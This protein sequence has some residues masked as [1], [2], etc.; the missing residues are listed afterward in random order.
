MFI[1]IKQNF[2]KI[3]NCHERPYCRTL[4]NPGE[5]VSKIMILHAYDWDPELIAQAGITEG[6]IQKLTPLLEEYLATFKESFKRSEHVVLGHVYVKGLM[7]DLE[8]KSIEPIALRYLDERGVRNLQYF[9]KDA[10]WD[11]AKMLD[12]YQKRL[13]LIVGDSEAMITVDG[14]DFPKKGKNSVGVARQYCG[15]LG[16]TE[17]CQAGAFVGYSSKN[18]YGLVNCRLYMPEKWFSDEYKDR[19]KAC[20]IPDD[21]TFKTKTEIAAELIQKTADSGLFPSKWIGCDSFFGTNREFLDS[22]PEGLYYFADV[23]ANINVWLEKPEV[24]IP[25]YK[26]RGPRPKKPKARTEPIPVSDIA[27]NDSIPWHTVVLG[28][29]AKGPIYARVKCVRVFECRD[30]LPGNECWL[31][32]REYAN[33]RIK[34]SLSNA[35]ADMPMETLNNV[36]I[37]RWPIEQS[38]EDGKSYLGMGDYE[39]RSWNAWHRHML[40]VFLAQL[41]LL[42]VRMRFKKNSNTDPSTGKAFTAC[43]IIS[44]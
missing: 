23:H 11:N 27:K 32:I 15:I 8:R 36:A 34:Y 37:M 26:G 6:E 7:S 14:C 13:P 5:R 12:I 17:N 4:E 16:K 19:W 18:G 35:P 21:I 22:L 1:H 41:F 20:A 39:F 33:G 42:E 10:L 28:N 25:E 40:F 38:F 29:G 31:Y 24:Y 3:I 44:E 2:R 9:M 30:N 43:S